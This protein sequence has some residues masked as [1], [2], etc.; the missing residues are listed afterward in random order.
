MKNSVKRRSGFVDLP[1]ELLVY[2]FSFLSAVRDKVALYYVSRRIRSAI[3]VPSLWKKFVWSYDSREERCVS[4]F[5]QTYGKYAI[6]TLSFPDHVSSIL[7]HTV[8]Y[9]HN[10]VELSLPL[11]KLDRVQVGTI[12]QHMQQLQKLDTQWSFGLMRLLVV[13]SQIKELT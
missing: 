6:K 8:R 11:I 7:L 5:L 2:T 9:C 13:K 1:T 10:V 4:D 3:E 12:V